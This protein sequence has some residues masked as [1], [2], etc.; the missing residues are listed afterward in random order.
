MIGREAGTTMA[1][2]GPILDGFDEGQRAQFFDSSDINLNPKLLSTEW[3]TGGH[4][5]GPQKAALPKNKSVGIF[6]E[7][8]ARDGRDQSQ[9]LAV[10]GN[11]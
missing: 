7:H 8:G 2:G 6:K 1:R 3:I 11:L 5:T 9:G 10:Q 4:Q